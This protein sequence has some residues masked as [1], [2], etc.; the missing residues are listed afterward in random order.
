[1]VSI[2]SMV[3]VLITNFASVE[4]PMNLQVF[5]QVW[6]GLLAWVGFIGFGLGFKFF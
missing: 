2:V 4:Q 5:G 1:M 3:D 6:R